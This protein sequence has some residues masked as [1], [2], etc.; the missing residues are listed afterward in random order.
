MTCSIIAG[1]PAAALRAVPFLTGTSSPNN[2]GGRPRSVTLTERP[3]GLGGRRMP[4]ALRFGVQVNFFHVALRAVHDAIGVGHRNAGRGTRP[5]SRDKLLQFTV[6]NE[7]L[8]LAYIS[9]HGLDS[10]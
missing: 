6:T 3:V 7:E 2:A 9:E 4:P 10:R 1:T 5:A 8:L